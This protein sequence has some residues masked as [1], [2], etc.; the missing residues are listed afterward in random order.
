MRTTVTA[1]SAEIEVALEARFA[2][3]V[4]SSDE[5]IISKNLDGIIVTW[6]PG[7]TQLFGY[8]AAEAIGR[9]VTM[10]IPEDRPNEEPDILA[11]LRRGERV[12]RYETVR[13]RKDGSLI[14]VS[15]TVSPIKDERGVVV[16][17]SKIA[18]DITERKKM[19]EQQALLVREMSHRVNN[20][21]TVTRSIVALTARSSATPAEM[22]RAIIGRIDALAG[23]HKLARPE[24]LA[25]GQDGTTLDELIQV[26]AAPYG[27]PERK[28]VVSVLAEGP[29][30]FVHARAVTPLSLVLHELAT[31]ASKY[32]ALSSPERG[33]VRIGWAEKD[34]RL[35]LDWRESG[36][37]A[38]DPPG[39]TGF[40]TLLVDR[41]VKSQL[42]GELEYDWRREGLAIR[43]AMP[44]ERLAAEVDSAPVAGRI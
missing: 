35:F 25:N 29:R 23:A 36:G 4:E 5:A 13:R 1:F 43:L 41:A 34:G 9:P 44:L 22:A 12:D 38:V 17:A 2:A 16:G 30:I 28:K 32:G 31:N 6:N 42:G 40:G 18:R 27:D 7:A 39:S 15:L 19:Q 37:P 3:I 24:S 20:L 21:L 26:I 10:L 8:T 14:D 11:R 33:C